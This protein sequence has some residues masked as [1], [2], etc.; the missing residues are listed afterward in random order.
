ME[1]NQNELIRL[2]KE[3]D[4]EAQNI[5]GAQLITGDHIKKD[6]LDGFYWYC[7]AIKKGY[8]KAKWN[9]GSMLLYGECEV[10]KNEDIGLSL[11]EDAAEANDNSACLFISRCYLKGRFGKKVDLELA[12]HWEQRAWDINNKKDFNRP[13][14]IEKEYGIILKR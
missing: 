12:K 14:D 11:I 2:A 9:A 13:I 8:V 10:E 6:I 7:Q 3:G 4:A 1:N 5:L